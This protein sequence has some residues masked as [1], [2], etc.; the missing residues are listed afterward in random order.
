MRNFL[1]FSGIFLLNSSFAFAAPR[2]YLKKEF[3]LTNSTG[4][5][6]LTC[7]F[8]S[9]QVEITEDTGME[10]SVRLEP[11]PYSGTALLALLYKSRSEPLV[12][13]PFNICDGGSL[14]IKGYKY[15]GTYFT[16][17]KF[18]DCGP[19]V[20]TRVGPGSTKLRSI[21]DEYCK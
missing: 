15:A 1:L 19:T 4:T 8:Y 14:W 17:K 13:E 12:T 18:E 9:R 10:S 11:T 16:L 21:V 2:L 20:K 6:K 5:Y 7:K 3:S